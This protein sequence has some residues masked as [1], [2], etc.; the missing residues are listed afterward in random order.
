MQP[1]FHLIPNRATAQGTLDDFVQF[2]LV[3]GKA[4]YSW[5]IGDIVIDRFWKG[6]GLLKHHPNLGA[7]LNRINFWIV[8][9]FTIDPNIAHD[10]AHINRVIHAVDTSQECR[11]P[12]TRWAN[13]R[14]YS[15]VFDFDS[16]IFDGVIISIKD[17]DILC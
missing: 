1:I 13:K 17:L 2:C 15:L 5:P 11:F 10:T 14:C 4:M 6:V 7:Q 3:S 12:A 8:D 16:D 9:I